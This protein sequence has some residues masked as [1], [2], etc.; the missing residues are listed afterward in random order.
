MRMNRVTIG[1]VKRPSIVK[2]FVG[3][4]RHYELL[5]GV[6]HYSIVPTTVL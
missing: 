6:H 2:L 3:K 5:I 4:Y 1:V